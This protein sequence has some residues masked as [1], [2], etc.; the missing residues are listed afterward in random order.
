MMPS[1]VIVVSDGSWESEYGVRNF[2][3]RRLEVE[4]LTWKH[5]AEFYRSSLPELTT[6]AE[7]HIWGKK[8]A[9]ILYLSEIDRV[10]FSDPEVLWY[11]DPLTAEEWST[12]KFKVSEDCCH[13]YDKDFIKNTA[14]E[15]LYD[16]EHPINCGVVYIHGGLK[17]LNDKALDCIRYQ[18]DHCGDFAEQTVFAI[19]D[20]QYNNRWTGEEIISAIDDVVQPLFSKTIKY[21][22]SV[23]RHYLWHLKWIYW[24]EYFKMRCF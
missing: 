2:R 17:L 19:M 14:S 3:Q 4:C 21:S 1:R 22:N 6:W 15:Y 23:A 10:L 16:T 20:L 13:S 5:C 11:G 7:K 9:C 24:T 8:M 18:A 12:T